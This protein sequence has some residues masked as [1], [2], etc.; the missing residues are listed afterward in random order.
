M[1][2]TTEPDVAGASKD[3]TARLG[4]PTAARPCCPRAQG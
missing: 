3:T 4:A 1:L 2:G